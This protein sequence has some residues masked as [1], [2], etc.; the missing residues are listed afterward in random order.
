MKK[1]SAR[2]KKLLFLALLVLAVALAGCEGD[3]GPAGPA[4]P[5]GPP[6][7]PGEPAAPP[8]PAS[9]TLTASESCTVC[10]G[11]T[12]SLLPMNT[13]HDAAVINPVNTLSST[14]TGVSFPVAPAAIQPTVTF[15]VTLNGAPF[16]GLAAN[17]T[18]KGR[19][20]FGIA[21]LVPGTPNSWQSYINRGATGSPGFGPSDETGD[22]IP[23]PAISGR[24]PQGTTA[25]GSTGGT[26]VETATPGTYTFTFNQDLATAETFPASGSIPGSGI[27]VGYNLN[28]THRV[29]IQFSPSSPIPTDARFNTFVDVVP[30]KDA[31][32]DGNADPAVPGVDATRLVATTASCLECHTLSVIA[33]RWGFH[34]SGARIE[35]GFCVLC[36]N[37]GTTDPES[38]ETV[39]LAT[40][41]HKIHRGR[42]LPTVVAGG[43]YIIWG[44]SN[45]VHDYSHVGYPQD[46]RNCQKC[47]TAADAAT[48]DGD[49][50][51]NRPSIE[52]CGAC[53][54]NISFVS[55][56]PAGKVLH[57]GGVQPNNDGC[58]LC[59]PATGAGIGQSVTAAHAIPGRAEAAAFQFN[60]I[61]VANT[62]PGQTPSVTFSVTDPT[63]ANAP[64]NIL[65]DAPFTVGGGASRLAVIIGWKTG[66]VGLGVPAIDWTN[67]GSGNNVGQP[68][69]I[70]PLAAGVAT[71]NPDGSFT[72]TSPVAI[73]L[74]AEG[75]G[76]AALEGHPALADGT[77]I[78]VKNAFLY[79]GVTDAVPE[80]RREVVTAAG[81]PLKCDNCHD[82]LSVHGANRTD[83]IEVCVVCHNPN[84]TDIGRRPADGSAGIDG[85]FEE[86]I[87][88]KNMIHAIHASGEG[89]GDPRTTPVVIYGFGGTPNDFSEVTFPGNM[90]K[91]THCHEGNTWQLPLQDGILA[92]TI[93]SPPDKADPD[94][95]G[96]ITKT[97]GVCS[98]CHD[99]Q[100]FKAHMEAQG[101]SF[102]VRQGN[103]IE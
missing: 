8:E 34:G 33:P 66:E 31:N 15:T 5:A 6:G 21:K 11:P 48:P 3:T 101:A 25:S 67:K 82:Q 10:H 35:V 22:G 74:D 68:V 62:A 55:P 96:N 51:M 45:G 40:M 43:K 63:N 94:D 103:I 80:P 44:Y 77:R 50:W 93:N 76:I 58:T 90:R 47:H 72:V 36:H 37:P 85:K 84:A 24:V 95:D 41:V 4:G 39:N 16:T 89:G 32:L 23:D 75:T 61:S 54:D 30:A 56:A 86:A 19:L 73:P 64:Y 52:A 83:S 14:I 59:H 81:Q 91:C 38:G 88:F 2:W 46:V 98:A 87:D 69:S 18:A 9:A 57:T 92:T 100:V 97:A 26:L 12:A 1:A 71:A 42:D 20:A 102:N 60:V 99:A 28:L 17:A 49:N 79:F 53:H 78:P 29:G 7:T 13:V 27:L 65:T 70:N